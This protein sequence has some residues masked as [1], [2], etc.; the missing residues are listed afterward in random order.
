MLY[1]KEKAYALRAIFEL[2][3]QAAEP[4]L[5]C[6]FIAEAQHIPR[7]FLEQIMG[8]LKQGGLLI[9]KRG[10]KGGYTLSRPPGDIMVSDIFDILD[11]SEIDIECLVCGAETP[12]PLLE[13]CPF[14]PFWQRVINAVRSVITNTS[15]QDL[16]DNEKSN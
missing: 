15:I 16:I 3:R 6:A 11:A 10:I 1:T 13:G 7:S 14:K 5:K 8:K 12:C 9:S 4:K 2:A